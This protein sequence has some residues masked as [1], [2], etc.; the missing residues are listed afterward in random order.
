MNNYDEGP[1]ELSDREQER[2]RTKADWQA[3]TDRQ[4]GWP[5]RRGIKGRRIA[6][7]AGFDS[8]LEAA[9]FGRGK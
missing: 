7:S 6:S 9:V 8:K 3:K 1:E 4:N 2:P 5:P